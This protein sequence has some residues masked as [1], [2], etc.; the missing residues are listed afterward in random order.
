[1][2]YRVTQDMSKGDRWF[3]G[4]PQADD[5]TEIDARLFTGC[6]PYAGPLPKVVPI[7]NPGYEWGFNLAAFDMPVV[8]KDVIEAILSLSEGR[9]ERYP[10]DVAGIKDKYI[11]LNVLDSSRCIDEEKSEIMRWPANGRRPELAGRYRMITNLTIDPART[12]GSHIFRLVGWE[13]ALIVSE[14]VKEAI[15]N[16]PEL[17]VVFQPVVQP[18]NTR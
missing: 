14:K 18:E 5:G 7:D 8:S 15:A 4:I 3:L 16:I 9:C 1:M 13:I 17:G 10:V 2:Y 11:I 6:K 12:N